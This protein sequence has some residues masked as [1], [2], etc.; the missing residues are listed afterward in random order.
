MAFSMKTVLGMIC[1]SLVLI[2]CATKSPTKP[3]ES[4]AGISAEP[5][6][7]EVKTLMSAGPHQLQD[8]KGRPVTALLLHQLPDSYLLRA[9][10]KINPP[11]FALRQVADLQ[12]ERA[13]WLNEALVVHCDGCQSIEAIPPL[14]VLPEEFLL[15][16]M[17]KIPLRQELKPEEMKKI[18]A[19][20]P[21][22]EVLWVILASED[23]ERRRG[24][25]KEAGL[26]SAWS[27]S[28]VQL[29]SF[30]YDVKSGKW[31]H[32]AQ[33][34]GSDQDVIVYEK[35]REEG[36]LK[37]PQARTVPFQ[38]KD[39]RTLIPEGSS[40]DGLKYD[41]V[42]PYPAVPETQRIYQHALQALTAN[43]AN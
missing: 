37:V 2:S 31:L 7:I 28:E 41:E 23:Y 42:Y 43:L 27:G 40:F 24:P 5:P 18:A 9:K 29:R 14:R 17:D 20:L 15:N 10:A 4:L 16:L 35:V 12:A 1:L 39:L 19:F 36:A 13:S 26:I 8:L 38:T 3:F 21:S 25:I 22:A 6:R 32:K 33:V 11:D 30:L 34:E